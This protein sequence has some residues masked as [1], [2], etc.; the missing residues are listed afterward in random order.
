MG[1]WKLFVDNGK[2]TEEAFNAR[3]SFWLPADS[4]YGN[5]QLKLMKLIMRVDEINRNLSESEK[6]WKLFVVDK[7][8]LSINGYDKHIFAN[9]KAIYFMRRV[10][11]EI[12]SLIWC[13]M[14]FEEF[15][16]YPKKI[17]IDRIGTMLYSSRSGIA[18][19][20][21]KYSQGLNAL[22]EIS[23]AFKHS[24][25]NSD[26]NVVGKNEPCV[27]ALDLKHN[28][29]QSGDKF[30]SVSL[31]SIVVDFNLF[32]KHGI[33]WLRGFSER[34]RAGVGKVGVDA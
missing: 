31:K 19:Y 21:S 7:N 9:E 22:N 1:E 30:Y 20:F 13:L 23:N 16:K 17:E 6:N 3:L 18:K 4:P 28:K 10:A 12:I 26:I 15:K 27:Q 33:E 24:F 11:D 25:I 34:N 8:H 29:I 32:Y 14:Y 2:R 5:F